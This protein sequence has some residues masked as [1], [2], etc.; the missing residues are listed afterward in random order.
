MMKHLDPV[1]G[2]YPDLVS[3]VAKTDH[4][5]GPVKEPDPVGVYAAPTFFLSAHGKIDDLDGFPI[6]GGIVY[7]V[8]NPFEFAVLFVWLYA[9]VKR[10]FDIFQI[11]SGFRRKG[12]FNLF[13]KGHQRIIKAVSLKTLSMSRLK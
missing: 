2:E 7:L 11:F 13:E 8:Q 5:K 4:V 1:K 10:V 3:L 9:H 6:Y 12:C